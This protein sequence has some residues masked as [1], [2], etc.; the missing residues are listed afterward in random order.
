METAARRFAINVVSVIP[1]VGQLINLLVFLA[2]V[3]MIFTDSQRQVVW[4]KIAKT[5]VISTK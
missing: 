2:S 4:D 3:V 5:L 1:G